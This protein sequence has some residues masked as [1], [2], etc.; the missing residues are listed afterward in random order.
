ME[1]VSRQGGQGVSPR[2][3]AHKT[4][5]GRE[6][7]SPQEDYF[8]IYPRSSSFPMTRAVSSTIGTMRAAS[9]VAPVLVEQALHDRPVD[10]H[11]FVTIEVTELD[12]IDE[13]VNFNST[14]DECKKHRD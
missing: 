7:A 10:V 8:P 4:L 9:I 1:R 14:T 3:P 5:K 12:M 6:N 11:I 13:E 2:R